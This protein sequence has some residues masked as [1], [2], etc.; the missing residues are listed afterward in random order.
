MRRQ[1]LGPLVAEPRISVSIPCRNEQGFIGACLRSII[2][3]DRSGMHVRVFVCDGMSDDGTR[4]EIAPLLALN[5]F[6][7]LIENPQRTT[8]IAMNLGLRA[9]PCDVG[10]ILGAHAEVAPDFFK[11]NIAALRSAAEAGCAGGVIESIYTDPTSRAIGAA[12]AH[13]FGVGGAHFRTGRKSGF[14]DTVAFGAYRSEVFER[15][16]WFDEMLTRNQ[17]DEFNFRLTEAGFRILLDPAIRSRYVVRA[18]FNKLWR[19]Y[20]QYGYWKVYVN[21]K[22]RSVTTGRQLVPAAW[23]AFL[24]LGGALALFFPWA[25][26]FFFGGIAAYVLAALVA[27][28]SAT[29]A[30]DLPRVLRAFVTLH[31]AYGLGYWAGIFRFVLRGASP[32]RSSETLSR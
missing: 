31:A 8:P 15:V 30:V 14:V 13:P 32:A 1:H 5:S 12:M 27:G 4:Q 2:A 23:I 21:W 6:I 10:I 16:G 22:H 18:S 11:T 29:R 26:W 28:L 20:Y 3:A 9:V 7:S 19:Q 24:A 25:R 17:D